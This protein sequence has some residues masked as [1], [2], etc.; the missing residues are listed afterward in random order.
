[1]AKTILIVE[2]LIQIWTYDVSHSR[3]LLR[4]KKTSAI[5]TTLDLVF[6]GVE[7]LQLATGMQS[8]SVEELTDAEARSELPGFTRLLP[9][10]LKTFRLTAAP[11][12]GYIVAA[13]LVWHEDS[14]NYGDPSAVFKPGGIVGGLA[15]EGYS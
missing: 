7:F 14:R 13:K 3:L 11:E 10:T 5:A 9:S 6:V 12:I 2:G 8:P 4:R 15:R 1:M